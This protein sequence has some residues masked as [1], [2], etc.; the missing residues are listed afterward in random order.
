[1]LGD[2][3]T[4]LRVQGPP[5]FY[6]GNKDEIPAGGPVTRPV[7]QGSNVEVTVDLW[8]NGSGHFTS[9]TVDNDETSGSFN[10]ANLG[11]KGGTPL[12][13]TLTAELAA[14]GRPG[15]GQ[16]IDTTGPGGN[17]GAGL[18]YNAERQRRDPDHHSGSRVLR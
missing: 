3:G 5:N 16:N 12:A 15:S 8:G 7:A 10:P 6:T 4:T 14:T 13:G 2:G 9:G 17:A 18:T 1:M 11:H